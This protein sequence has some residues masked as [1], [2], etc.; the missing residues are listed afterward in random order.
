MQPTHQ[1]DRPRDGKP[2][3]GSRA[4]KIMHQHRKGSTPFS[5]L[6][7]SDITENHA[8]NYHHFRQLGET[9]STDD[10]DRDAVWVV[11]TSPAQKR[12]RQDE[13]AK[14]QN[15]TLDEQEFSTFTPI[16][17][18]SAPKGTHSYE[19]TL[20]LLGITIDTTLS[21]P[22]EVDGP[23][24][25]AYVSEF[26][27]YLLAKSLEE[28]YRSTKPNKATLLHKLCQFL[29]PERPASDLKDF[30]MHMIFEFTGPFK[31]HNLQE[32]LR[33][34]GNMKYP[35]V[36]RPLGRAAMPALLQTSAE[37]DICSQS[38]FVFACDWKELGDGVME[39]ARAFQA[40]FKL[41]GLS[42]AS[43]SCAPAL[44][45]EVKVSDSPASLCEARH[46]W[47]SLAYLNLLERVT[48]IRA[49][50]Y[51]DDANICQFGYL[52][53]GLTIEVWK[54]RIH[55]VT[56]MRRNSTLYPDYFTF[57][58]NCVR[59][60]D[61]NTQA[62]VRRFMAL[63]KRILKWSRLVYAKD[64]INDVQ[65]IASEKQDMQD[66]FS[67]WREA[68]ERCECAQYIVHKFDQG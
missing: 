35:F 17:K 21:H 14:K 64:Y 3:R 29:F 66:W 30:K 56:G 51:A 46:Q 47:A 65:A 62:G 37:N 16:A 2:Y 15:R 63:H 18:S 31:N 9:F 19:Q 7:R 10:Y 41:P 38:D 48:I 43:R 44:V 61:I 49:K 53:C 58:I 57:P 45:G 13:A 40:N 20:Y 55:K 24:P 50:P 33:R 52:I 25:T 42:L 67:T 6:A 8:D 23:E 34:E 5:F 12:Q 27:P 54:M 22:P 68:V 36:K 59:V 26:D 28:W 1:Q 60:F 11:A 39:R 4:S 32:L